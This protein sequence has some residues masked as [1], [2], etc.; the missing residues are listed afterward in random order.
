M[1][2]S[3]VLALEKA[4]EAKQ[5]KVLKEIE[6]YISEKKGK[7]KESKSL[8]EKKINPSQDKG[9]SAYFYVFEI[10][11]GGEVVEKLKKEVSGKNLVTSHLLQRVDIE[12]RKR[13]EIKE[14]KE[15]AKKKVAK[16]KEVVKADKILDSIEEEKEKIKD[17]DS[18][19]DKILN[20]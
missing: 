12:R 1:T 18:E 10:D 6:D 14:K 9:A 2:Y 5:K 20:E 8:G 3:L 4:P 7:V 16:K 19:L 17:L 13:A 11:L 15:R